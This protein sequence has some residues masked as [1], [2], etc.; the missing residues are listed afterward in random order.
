MLS[1]PER[2]LRRDPNTGESAR[3]PLLA[4]AATAAA[5]RSASS[6]AASV[7]AALQKQAQSFTALITVSLLASVLLLSTLA[8][9]S[10]TAALFRETGFH[11]H[12][13][14]GWVYV[15]NAFSSSPELA[16]M[17]ACNVMPVLGA[18]FVVSWCDSSFGHNAERWKAASFC[19]ALLAQFGLFLVVF[20][21]SSSAGLWHRWGVGMFVLFTSALHLRVAIVD[22]GVATKFNFGHHTRNWRILLALVALA[23]L[24]AFVSNFQ[25][26]DPSQSSKMWSCLG[27]YVILVCFVLLNMLSA[28]CVVRVAFYWHLV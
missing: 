8:Q 15:S 6:S 12:P 23:G 14:W 1:N 13:E 2:R 9:V 10:V 5:P 18:L 7:A 11:A 16:V 17:W 26:N 28:F 4:P 27:E 21:D 22:E 24:L 25:A 20:C 3:T 19:A